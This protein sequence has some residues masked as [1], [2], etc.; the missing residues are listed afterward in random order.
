MA[1]FLCE[2]GMRMEKAGRGDRL[3]FTLDLTQTQLGEALGLTPV[4]VNRTLKA[5]RTRHLVTA[6]G[7]DFAVHDWDQ[8]AA[9]G[10]FDLTYLQF[11]EEV[12]EAA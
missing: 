1:H 4:H 3:N 9:L 11:D 10:E 2:F 5:L 12:R 7:R 8:L 6:T